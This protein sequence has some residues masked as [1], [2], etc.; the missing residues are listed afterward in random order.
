[1]D[2]EPPQNISDQTYT[3]PP[4]VK[5]LERSYTR[6]FK[7][8]VLQFLHHHRVREE[9]PCPY[10]WSEPK[11]RIRKPY[12]REA[13]IHFQIPAQNISHWRKKEE[14]ILNQSKSSRRSKKRKPDREIEIQSKDGQTV[15]VLHYDIL[16][17]EELYQ[18]LRQRGQKVCGKKDEMLAR[19]KEFDSNKDQS[20]SE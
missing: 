19:L 11:I 16:T 4:R 15:K 1:M 5:R 13:A 7:L 20:A 14:E 17:K 2:A 18:E 10:G 8:K 12:L 6:E 9:I 3:A